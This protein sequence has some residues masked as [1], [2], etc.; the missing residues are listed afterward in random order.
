MPHLNLAKLEAA[1]V[2]AEPYEFVV[3]PGFLSPDV[4]LVSAEAFR[5]VCMTC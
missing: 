1:T 2:A 5:R 3:V 4:Q